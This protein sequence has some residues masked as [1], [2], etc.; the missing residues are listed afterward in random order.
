MAWIEKRGNKFRVRWETKSSNNKRRYNEETFDTADDAKQYLKK[1]EYESSIGLVVSSTKMTVA[2]YLGHWLKLHGNA[3]APKTLASYQCEIKNHV[4][5]NLG[6]IKLSRLTPLDLQNYYD[7]LLKRGKK[8]LLERYKEGLN[9]KRTRALKIVEKR[10]ATMEKEGTGGLSPTTVRYQHRI[11]HKALQQAYLWQMIPR[12]VAD[13]VQLP[14]AKKVEI[15]YLQKDQVTKF[16]SKIKGSE[17]YPVIAAAIMTGMRQ[18][19]ILGLR[20]QDVDLDLGVIHVRQQV[21]YL[22]GRGFFFKEPKQSSK[23]DIPPCSCRSM[24]SSGR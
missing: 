16:I 8:E 20:W 11:L 9:K 3:L 13:A 14:K 17:H 7:T 19:E 24:L 22:P 12:N 1:I 21:Q 4:I 2:E 5:P 6:D 15:D 10:L 23:R 18:G